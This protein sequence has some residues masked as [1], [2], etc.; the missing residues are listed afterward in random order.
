MPL[1][2]DHS[3]AALIAACKAGDRRA[4]EAFFRRFFPKLL[5]ITL[6][7]LR[8]REEAVSVLNHAMLRIFQSL[9]DY[10][11]E[12]KLEGWLATIVRRTALNFIRDEGRARRRF[13]PAAYDPPV[14]VAN[15]AL[16]RLQAEDIIKLLHALPDYLRIVFSLS[17]FDGLAHKEIATELDITVAA[18]RWRLAKARELLRDRYTSANHLNESLS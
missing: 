1:R 10:R 7:Y 9:D 14:S 3:T 5:P 15:G 17:V 8:N 4:Q 18:S 11:E 12:Q 13:Q 2:P 16:D 6:R